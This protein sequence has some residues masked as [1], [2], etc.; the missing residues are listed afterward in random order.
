[1]TQTEKMMREAANVDTMI[2]KDKY[3]NSDPIPPNDIV[4]MFLQKISLEFPKYKMFCNTNSSIRMVIMVVDEMDNIV[5]Y[6]IEINNY[7]A[8]NSYGYPEVAF[9]VAYRHDET[10]NTE[11]W[12]DDHG[13]FCPEKF[14]NNTKV[15]NSEGDHAHIIVPRS[16]IEFVLLTHYNFN[17]KTGDFVRINYTEEEMSKLDNG[18]NGFLFRVNMIPT[19]KM[20]VIPEEVYDQHHRV[21]VLCNNEPHALIIFT[22]LGLIPID[23]SAYN[24]VS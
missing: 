3:E 10:L 7:D 15:D 9:A 12:Q 6:I 13:N 19:F 22:L 16:Y 14:L 18:L 21:I 4:G 17:H 8:S 2:Y 1:M 5:P 20:N 11:R 23:P 24:S